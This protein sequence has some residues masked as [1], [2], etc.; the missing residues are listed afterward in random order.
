MTERFAGKVVL[1]T[2]GGSGLGRSAA[3]EVAR[4]GAKLALVDVN[5]KALEETKRVISEEVQ[6]AEFLLIEGDV[7]DE[8]AVKS[9]LV[10][11]LM[12]LGVSMHFQQCRH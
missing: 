12:N 4:E 3:V 8:E 7:S 2:G 9:M 1:I 11:R 10:I 5:M 6:H